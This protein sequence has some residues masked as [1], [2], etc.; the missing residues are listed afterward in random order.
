MEKRMLLVLVFV[1]L[2]LFFISS[3]HAEDIN[4]GTYNLSE[5]DNKVIS[6]P[7]DLN[8]PSEPTKETRAF[9]ASSTKQVNSAS[10][11]YIIS[12]VGEVYFNDHFEFLDIEKRDFIQFYNYN[13][14]YG[15]YN[16]KL[17]VAISED[18]VIEDISHIIKS[19]QEIVFSDKSASSK[20]SEL[21]LGEPTT[22][23]LVFSDKKQTLAWRIDWNHI[24]TE[25]E[26]TNK[27]VS[28]YL[29]SVSDGEVLDTFVYEIDPKIGSNEQTKSTSNFLYLL[30]GGIFILVIFII[31][32]TRRK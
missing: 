24:P 30:I 5:T 25:E 19:P 21:G 3:I 12:K 23:S 17:F 10:D 9:A 8:I 6:S 4:L 1:V 7:Q 16:T 27:S 2:S 18:G 20:V 11:S 13:F 29:L 14:K 22:I 32:L 15:D 28:G 31:A 26:I